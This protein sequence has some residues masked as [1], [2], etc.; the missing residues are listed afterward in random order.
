MFL[1]QGVVQFSIGAM[2]CYLQQKYF[3]AFA[4]KTW[5]FFKQNT[6]YYLPPQNHI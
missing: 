1:L 2:Y 6:T 3:T 5:W 4:I